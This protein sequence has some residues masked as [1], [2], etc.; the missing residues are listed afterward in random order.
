M[1]LSLEWN[2]A[3]GLHESLTLSIPALG[4]SVVADTYYVASDDDVEPG[5]TSPSRIEAAI[6]T[7][8]QGWI[9]LIRTMSSRDIRYLPF[10]FSDQYIGCLKIEGREGGQVGMSYGYTTTI[11]GHGLS[12]S[13]PHSLA[14]SEYDCIPDSAVSIVEREAL[15]AD[16][17]QALDALRWI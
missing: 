5:E 10:D 1:V 8:I 2:P 13:E 15:L 14:L 9:S 12:P 3:A 11:E 6:S 17:F 16:L 7:L 4:V